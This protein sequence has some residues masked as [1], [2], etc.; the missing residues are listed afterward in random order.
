[1]SRLRVAAH[2]IVNVGEFLAGGIE[3]E[4]SSW[5]WT[6]TQEVSWMCPWRSGMLVRAAASLHPLDPQT[7]TDLPSLRGMKAVQLLGS[8]K[9]FRH[10][11]REV[12]Y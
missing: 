4:I 9:V 7:P 12:K 10:R 3:V 5:P 1:M 2:A 6:C 8:L 11:E